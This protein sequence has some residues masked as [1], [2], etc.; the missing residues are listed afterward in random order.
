MHGKINEPE[1]I[2]YSQEY[3]NLTYT[4]TIIGYFS[5]GLVKGKESGGEFNIR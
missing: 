2:I 1:T 4:K 3:R 5:E